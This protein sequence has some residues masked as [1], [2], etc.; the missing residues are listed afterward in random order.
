[1]PKRR[2]GGSL[3]RKSSQAAIKKATRSQETG[4]NFKNS[5]G[6]DTYATKNKVE[7]KTYCRNH[8]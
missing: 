1:M 2:R 6:N 4:E 5:A 8:I 3:G 7:K